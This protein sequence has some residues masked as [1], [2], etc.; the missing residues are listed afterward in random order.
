M[1]PSFT[2][3]QLS[4]LLALNEARHFG[5]AARKV[6]VSQPTLSLQ[7]QKLEEELG[8]S[9]FDRSKQPI[10]PTEFGERIIEQAR[11]VLAEARALEGILGES[12]E[13]QGLFRI[14]II[15]T[16]AADLLPRFVPRLLREF[17]KVQLS[18]E[19]V[20]TEDIVNRLKRDE[21]D[22][23]LLVTPLNDPGLQEFPLFYEP[24]WVYLPEQ[25][26]L[27]KEKSISRKEL[28][29]A[30]LLLLSE[31]H[32][33][34]TQMLEV[35]RQKKGRRPEA[36]HFHFDSG[37]FE[38]LISLVD[39]GVGYTILPQLAVDRLIGTSARSKRLRAFTDPEPVREVSLVRSRL[40]SRKQIADEVSHRI[41]AEMKSELK[42]RPAKH[43][44][45]PI[46]R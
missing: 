27:L 39:G 20:V 10:L 7:I 9:L 4:Y 11:K 8:A 44:V 36:A 43:S 29:R 12:G 1:V 18:I 37:S 45:I 13:P 5:L 15:P 21:L 3:T 28:Q 42:V 24:L 14:G 22:A 33:F 40:F 35:C 30:D 23:G 41:Q 17:P 25:H 31:G 2:L 46:V 26:P 38:A 19:E 34:R 6:H 32:C 16:L